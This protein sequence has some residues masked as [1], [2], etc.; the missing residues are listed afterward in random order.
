[1]VEQWNRLWGGETHSVNFQKKKIFG[2]FKRYLAAWLCLYIAGCR[3][4]GVCGSMGCQK[5]DLKKLLY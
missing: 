1:M 4:V 5:R 2:L 3:V